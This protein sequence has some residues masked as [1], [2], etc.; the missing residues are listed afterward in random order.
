MR[1]RRKLKTAINVDNAVERCYSAQQRV[2]TI[3]VG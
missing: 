1:E 2:K 3:A